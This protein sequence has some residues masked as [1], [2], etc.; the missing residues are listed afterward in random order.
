MNKV[1]LVSNKRRLR[2]LQHELEDIGQFDHIFYL[3]AHTG[4][5]VEQLKEYLVSKAERRP[6]KIHPSL[7]T[8]DLEVEKA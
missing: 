4:Y 2:E 8:D 5:G 3:S 7:V 6:W 1:D